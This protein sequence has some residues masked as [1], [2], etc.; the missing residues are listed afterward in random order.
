MGKGKMS[1]ATAAERSTAMSWIR[2]IGL[3]A[4][5]RLYAKAHRMITLPTAAP[6]RNTENYAYSIFSDLPAMRVRIYH[7]QMHNPAR[8]HHIAKTAIR[9]EEIARASGL[10]D[11]G[12]RAVYKMAFLA[13]GIIIGAIHQ[14]EAVTA[15]EETQKQGKISTSLV[16][17]IEAYNSIDTDTPRVYLLRFRELVVFTSLLKR[18]MRQYQKSLKDAPQ[19]PQQ[20]RRTIRHY[21]D[22]IQAIL[23]R[24]N[25]KASSDTTADPGTYHRFTKIVKQ[26]LHGQLAQTSQGQSQRQ[27]LRSQAQPS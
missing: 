4:I 8:L 11:E 24:A 5:S 26:L 23:D 6:P 17:I 25:R 21:T 15:L 9:A 2:G 3:G 7:L 12:Q 13:T 27:A 20:H 18:R 19:P 10:D 16:Q 14:E 1:E 22:A